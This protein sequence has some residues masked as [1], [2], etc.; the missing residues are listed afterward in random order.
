[1]PWADNYHT[2]AANLQHRILIEQV[3]QNWAANQSNVRVRGFL[4][5]NSDYRVWNLYNN[6]PRN[7]TGTNSW[8][9]GPFGFDTQPHTTA[10]Y[11]D[12][13]F[14]VNHDAAGNC[15]VSYTVYYGDTT[16]GFDGPQ[17]LGVGMWLSRIP[18]RPDPPGQPTFS[19][20]LPTS[21]TVSWTASPNDQGSAITEYLLRRWDAATQ[22]GPYTDSEANNLTRNIIALTPGFTYT[23]AVYAK[24]GAAD[25]GGWSNVSEDNHIQ[26]PAGVWVRV[27]GTWKVTVPYIRSGG[28]WKMA[29]PYV[30]KGGIWKQPGV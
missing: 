29:M 16:V 11:I 10:T 28:T 27:G 25:N 4:I 20:V 19:N 14:T 5:N 26:L 13:T 15:Y 9:P 3:S 7:I 22:T 2:V 6:I 12:G 18:K 23:F 21:L 1:M 8:Y 17:S 24:N 30:R